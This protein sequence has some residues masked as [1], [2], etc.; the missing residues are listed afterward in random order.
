M[1]SKKVG[2]HI[3][4]VNGQYKSDDM[5]G[6][7]VHDFWCIDTKDF[8]YKVLRFN[9]VGFYKDDKEGKKSMCRELEKMRA[10]SERKGQEIGEAIGEKRGKA[11]GE[12]IGEE[13]GKGKERRKA[14]SNL[15]N[16]GQSAENVI[17]LGYPEDLVREIAAKAV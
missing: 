6:K 5:L 7:L 2:Q 4:Y 1:A 11:L 17:A 3:I 15:L 13:S 12:A 14:I 10:D 16:M 8:H 9:S